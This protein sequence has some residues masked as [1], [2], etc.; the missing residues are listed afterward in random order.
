MRKH[1]S[2]TP[3]PTL[4]DGK[5][6]A[7]CCQWK[8]FSD[9]Y[10]NSKAADKHMHHCKPCTRERG[11]QW[12]ARNP[13]LVS[14]GKVRHYWKHR[15]ALLQANKEWREANPERRRQ[16]W[17]DWKIAN[18][19]A[20]R[21]MNLRYWNRNADRLRA[22]ARLRYQKSAVDGRLVPR[23][24]TRRARKKGNGGS[25]T[26]VEW[27]ALCAKYGNICLRCRQVAKLTVDHVIPIV[28]GGS[29]DIGNI[30]PLC[31]TCNK[32]KGARSTDYRSAEVSNNPPASP[33]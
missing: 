12:R 15:E 9:Y 23:W 1:T 10:N 30:Q 19:E 2:S 27:R 5:V 21:E 4:F 13:D 14:A 32:S 7:D 24:Q 18:P 33:S 11:R 3:P 20:S 16:A 17:R 31:E 8:P 28:R 22:D 25:F 6:C 29:N 26:L